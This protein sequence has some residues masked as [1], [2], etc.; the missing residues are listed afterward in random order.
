MI[1]LL[2]LNL[3]VTNN[4]I[5]KQQS[6]PTA[7]LSIVVMFQ[8]IKCNFKLQLQIATQLVILLLVMLDD[9]KDNF[10]KN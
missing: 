3:T 5:M 1:T 6:Y 7:I 8:A 9:I 10:T 4:N 2:A